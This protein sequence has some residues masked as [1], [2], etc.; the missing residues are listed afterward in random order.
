MSTRKPGHA[1]TIRLPEEVSAEMTRRAVLS[2]IPVSKWA[3]EVVESFI[4]GERCRHTP[5]PDTPAATEAPAA[6]ESTLGT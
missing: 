5:R 6:D 4:A 1:L 3:A 2:G